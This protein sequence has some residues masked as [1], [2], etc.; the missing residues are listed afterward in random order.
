M[1][2]IEWCALLKSYGTTSSIVVT[3]QTTHLLVGRLETVPHKTLSVVSREITVLSEDGA[4]D[5]MRT[6]LPSNLT[7]STT[8]TKG[9]DFL[10]AERLKYHTHAL[11]ALKRKIH[12]RGEKTTY[13][14]SSDEINTL[15]EEG[16]QVK[17]RNKG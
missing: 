3:K 11:T 8:T 16:L 6:R 2:H 13:S 10:S 7:T 5:L 17:K 12:S 14:E 15:E 4:F 9:P 1:R